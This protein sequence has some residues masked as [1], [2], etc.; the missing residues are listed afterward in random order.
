[1]IVI[2]NGGV[3]SMIPG[4]SGNDRKLRPVIDRYPIGKHL[5]AV[6]HVPFQFGEAANA[7]P[8]APPHLNVTPNYTLLRLGQRGLMMHAPLPALWR[9]RER[10]AATVKRCFT[11]RVSAASAL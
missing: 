2:E 4:V 8:P 10:E 3:K 9:E 1:M 6:L 11:T 7:G 5:C